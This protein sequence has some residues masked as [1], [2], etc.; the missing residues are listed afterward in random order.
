[1][2]KS[3]DNKAELMHIQQDA[4]LAS[5]PP[6]NKVD[7]ATAVVMAS[8]ISFGDKNAGLQV[9]ISN[10][11][12]TAQFHLPPGKFL[13]A[14]LGFANDGAPPKNDPKHHRVHYPPFPF[15]ATRTLLIAGH[16]L[17]RFTRSAPHRHLE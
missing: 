3:P 12:I 2:H 14:R 13:R 8:A 10:G 5:P 9:G 11:P 4:C 6:K 15:A 1:M 16:Y 7:S 17:I